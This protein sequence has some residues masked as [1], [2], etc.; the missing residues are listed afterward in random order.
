MPGGVGDNEF[1]F[2]GGKVA[3]GHIDGDALFA[4]ALQTVYQQRQVKL[5]V[6]GVEA[7]GVAFDGRQMVFEN[8]LRVVQQAAD[9]GALAIVH[10]AAGEKAHQ[11]F[12]FVLFQVA[13]DVLF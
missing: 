3:V 13:E 9:Q 1:A 7:F 2:V 5:F 11:L 8:H 4:L 10:A 12:I 6:G